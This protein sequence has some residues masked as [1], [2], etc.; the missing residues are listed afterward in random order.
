MET[1]TGKDEM[2]KYRV[3][4]AT[5]T[6]G[7]YRTIAIHDDE[8]TTRNWG[9]IPYLYFPTTVEILHITPLG[10]LEI[11]GNLTAVESLQETFTIGYHSGI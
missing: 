5:Y 3:F 11:L 9:T 10:T 7:T 2:R 1:L 4:C 8:T 6:D